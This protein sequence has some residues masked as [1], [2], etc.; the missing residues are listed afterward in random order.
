MNQYITSE[1][2]IQRTISIFKSSGVGLVFFI[3][4]CATQADKVAAVSVSSQPYQ[5]MNCQQ[6]FDEKKR[7]ELMAMETAKLQQGEADR[8]SAA[9]VGMFFV[10]TLFVFAMQGNSATAYDLAALRGQFATIKSVE[11]EK[12]C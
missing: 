5:G 11:A 7:V 3:A 4:G 1:V 9:G 8:D 2:F 12:K 10:S 6:L